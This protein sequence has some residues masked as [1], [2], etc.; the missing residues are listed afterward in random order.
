LDVLALDGN[1]VYI[2]FVAVYEATVYACV[3]K[4]S[5]SIDDLARFRVS[6][7]GWNEHYAEVEA[8]AVLEVT[9]GMTFDLEAKTVVSFEVRSAEEAE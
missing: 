7:W 2:E 1:N 5:A 8:P 9:F 3:F 6:D 4:S